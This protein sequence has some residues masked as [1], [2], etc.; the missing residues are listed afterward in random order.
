MA[1][2]LCKVCDRWH[3]LDEP[4]PMECWRPARAA[5][6]DL[7][8]PMIISDE[9]PDTEHVDGRFYSSKS[10][11]RRVTRANGCIE[12]GDQKLP[13]RQIK[14]PDRKGIK[15]AVEK[16]KARFARGERATPA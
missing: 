7:A 4:W 15:D 8:F 16:A 11:Y 13:P 9:M 3:S 2:R 1:E 6:S 10:S 14:G 12:V 5:R